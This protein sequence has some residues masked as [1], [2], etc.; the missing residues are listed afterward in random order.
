MKKDVHFS[1]VE[2][3]RADK[4]SRGNEREH[5]YERAGEALSSAPIYAE[6]FPVKCGQVLY[7]LWT[8]TSFGNESAHP[9]D[10][11]GMEPYS[12]RRRRYVVL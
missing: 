4:K 2:R 10:R 3:K 11:A 6:Q 12:R 5:Y 7:P 1:S 9:T 8:L